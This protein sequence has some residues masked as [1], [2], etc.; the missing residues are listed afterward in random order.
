MAKDSN[1]GLLEQIQLAVRVGHELGAS[2]LQ[3]QGSVHSATLPPVAASSSKR[4]CPLRSYSKVL[5]SICTNTSEFPVA[6][7][8]ISTPEATAHVC[9]MSSCVVW[10][11]AVAPKFQLY[12]TA[13]THKHKFFIPDNTLLL[14]F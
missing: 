14:V 12:Y 1:L 2:D 10:L 7:K 4:F 3:V 5:R 9:V 6:Q 8:I 13:K 11:Y